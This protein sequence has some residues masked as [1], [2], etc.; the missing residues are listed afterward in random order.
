MKAALVRP[1]SSGPSGR[2]V[3]VAPSGPVPE[4]RLAEGLAA[5]RD[6]QIGEISLAANLGVKTGYFAGEDAVRLAA[7]QAALDDPEVT[8]IVC[9]RGGYGL[10]R[11]LPH[12]RAERFS[13]APKLLV[14]FSDAT[15]LLCWALGAGVC[16]VHGPVVT[17]LSALPQADAQRLATLM[18]GEL[19]APLSGD[20]GVGE[21]R[22]AGPLV[23]ANLEVLRSLVGTP[24]LPDLAGTIVAL[25]EIGERPYRLDRA[26]T[27][28]ITSG[29]FAGVRGF[30]IG[31]LYACDEPP[32][33]NPDSPDARTV[34]RERLQSLGVPLVLGLPF[35]HLPHEHA[36]LPCGSRVELDP[37][38]ATLSLLEPVAVRPG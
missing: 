24:W 11:L 12:L 31:Q 14:G 7:L 13:A 9:A 28:L 38:R 21:A 16:S 4:A 6:L 30:A 27:Q 3:V 35:G 25:E 29:A 2:V 22:V 36:A 19:P 18:R 1:P 17:Q 20:A 32:A 33:G 23:P 34:V 5:L 15:A 26:L 8:A 37:R 10:T